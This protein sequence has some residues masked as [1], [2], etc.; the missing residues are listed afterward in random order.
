MIISN[1]FFLIITQSFFTTYNNFKG[2]QEVA[3]LVH[4]E[5]INGI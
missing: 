5:K 4:R 1:Q 3:S 2:A